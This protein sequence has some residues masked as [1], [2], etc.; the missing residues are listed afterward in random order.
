MILKGMLGITRAACLE[1][2]SLKNREPLAACGIKPGEVG[3]QET[4]GAYM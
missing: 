2:V 4:S 3:F 1:A